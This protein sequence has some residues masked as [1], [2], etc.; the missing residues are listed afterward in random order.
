MKALSFGS[1]CS[2]R[3]SAASVTSTGEI[4]LAARRGASS[5]MLAN[6]RSV[7]VP[8]EQL[9]LG[10]IGRAQATLPVA[11][12]AHVARH[13]RQPAAIGLG[14]RVAQLA[15][16]ALARH[17]LQFFQARRRHAPLPFGPQAA[18]VPPPLIAR[19]APKAKGDPA[20]SPRG[21]PGGWPDRMEVAYTRAQT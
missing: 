13:G 14:L 20:R 8:S 21:R 10:R 6:A 2:R 7:M 1:S 17:A 5:A 16:E 11:Q 12:Q 15:A 3:A 19:C 4:S 9:D 18:L